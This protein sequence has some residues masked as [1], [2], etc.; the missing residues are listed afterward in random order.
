[1]LRA[2]YPRI[3]NVKENF[4]EAHVRSS[5]CRSCSCRF[6][7]RPAAFY[8]EEVLHLLLHRQVQR[9]LPGWLHDGLLQEQ[10]K[11][12]FQYRGRVAVAIRPRF[13]SPIEAGPATTC[14]LFEVRLRQSD[15]RLSQF[16]V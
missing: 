14:L 3:F 10:V 13:I 12:P 11:P 4:H 1:M 7:S 8:E 2:A 5:F 15:P 16:P 6:R 9:L